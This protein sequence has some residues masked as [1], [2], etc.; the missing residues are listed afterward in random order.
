[1]CVA[2]VLER[3]VRIPYWAQ[4]IYPSLYAAAMAPS[5][6]FH[7]T[8]AQ[9]P[10]VRLLSSFSTSRRRKDPN[11]KTATITDE[12][13]IVLPREF[14][15]EAF[16]EI[17]SEQPCGILTWGEIGLAL[18]RLGRDY[19]AGMVELLTELYD[20]PETPL[21]KR[22]RS[23]EWTI[24]NPCLSIFG[25]TTQH[26]LESSLTED[27]AL[28]GF[29]PRW[30]II[31]ATEPEE[32]IEIPPHSTKPPAEASSAH[33]ELFV[34]LTRPTPAQRSASSASDQT[35]ERGLERSTP[36]RRATSTR[37][38]WRRGLRASSRW[39]SSWPCCSSS[40]LPGS[41]ALPPQVGSGP[42]PS[43]TSWPTT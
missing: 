8:S 40:A 24:T 2:A 37:S 27:L 32:F 43:Q 12:A 20:C 28:G 33:S 3:R 38:C 14:S 18:K 41:R 15:T 11:N 17:L 22:L 7:K 16:L 4:H 1:V 42:V 19:N 6:R 25:A 23:G 39:R 21:V 30:L 5:S 34:A 35:T 10:P 13:P 31:P 29:L 26:W 36:G 9:A